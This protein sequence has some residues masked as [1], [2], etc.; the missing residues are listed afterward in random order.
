MPKL[1]IND[2]FNGQSKREYEKN[3]TRVNDIVSKSGENKV[4]RKVLAQTQ[5]DRITDEWKAINRAM[6][7][8][9][10]GHDDIFE[11]F[12]RRAYALEGIKLGKN[13]VQAEYR[14]YVL[15]KLLP[16]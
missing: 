6:V 11:V 9:E 16:E 1:D 12:F 7:A 8:K 14:D 3:F 10:L 2:P 15:Q 4:R 13:Q 5:A